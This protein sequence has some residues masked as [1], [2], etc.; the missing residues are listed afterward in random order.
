M[1]FGELGATTEPSWNEAVPP[2]ARTP[3]WT[4]MGH[5]VEG[6]LWYLNGYLSMLREFLETDVLQ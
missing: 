1:K 4:A 5:G 2:S 6:G 3:A